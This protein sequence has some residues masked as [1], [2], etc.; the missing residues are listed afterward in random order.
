MYR[1]INFKCRLQSYKMSTVHFLFDV[2]W[3]N[4]LV[5]RFECLVLALTLLTNMV[6]NSLENRQSIMD[7]MAA[8]KDAGFC[9]KVVLTL[10]WLITAVDTHLKGWDYARVPVYLRSNKNTAEIKAS[11]R[12]SCFLG[13]R[14]ELCVILAFIAV[15]S[16]PKVLPSMYV[17]GR[18][19]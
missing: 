17:H 4:F 9:V 3:A 15:L 13:W 2:P 16:F 5:R 10:H 18:V 11:F 7:S 12:W 1:A 8:Q 14:I 6:E 19:V